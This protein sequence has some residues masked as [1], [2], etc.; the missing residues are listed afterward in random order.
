[1]SKQNI[2]QDTNTHFSDFLRRQNNRNWNFHWW[3]SAS[4]EEEWK[5]KEVHGIF[6]LNSSFYIFLSPLDQTFDRKRF[7]EKRWN[8]DARI[9]LEYFPPTNF[10]WKAPRNDQRIFTGT[11]QKKAIFG[12]SSSGKL[13]FVFGFWGETKVALLPKKAVYFA[14]KT[15]YVFVKKSFHYAFCGKFAIFFKFKK[16]FWNIYYSTWILWQIRYILVYKKLEPELYTFANR[17]QILC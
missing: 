5:Q 15:R 17:W 6:L 12:S 16:C 9:T 13:V 10:A 7:L 14:F 1:M 11:L 3:T 8:K 4:L 2:R